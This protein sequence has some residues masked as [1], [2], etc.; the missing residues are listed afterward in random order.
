MSILEHKHITLYARRESDTIERLIMR[1]TEELKE[2]SRGAVVHAHLVHD[3]GDEFLQKFSN[4]VLT[5][6]ILGRFDTIDDR[7]GYDKG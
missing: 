5:R 1:L 3:R 4:E 2:T 7:A 6:G